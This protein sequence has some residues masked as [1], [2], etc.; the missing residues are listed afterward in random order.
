MNTN[1]II[2]D[3][4]YLLDDD[5]DGYILLECPKCG[6]QEQVNYLDSDPQEAIDAEIATVIASHKCR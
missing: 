3:N 4:R 6:V 1:W 2:T 5:Y